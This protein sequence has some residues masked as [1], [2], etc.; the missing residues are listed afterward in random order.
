MLYTQSQLDHI[1]TVKESYKGIELLIGKIISSVEILTMHHED[2][3]TQDE[4]L[5]YIALKNQLVKI[6]W[7]IDGLRQNKFFARVV[8]W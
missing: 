4:R 3:M 8:R 6:S 2:E 5:E 7:L 1:R